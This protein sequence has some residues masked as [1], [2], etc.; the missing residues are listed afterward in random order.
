M[1]FFPDGTIVVLNGGT[2][3]AGTY[4]FPDESHL[5]I[6]DAKEV[7]IFVV[8]IAD[9]TFSITLLNSSPPKTIVFERIHTR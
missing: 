7:N 1:Q 4:S 3:T 5:K 8:T 6:Q 2:S 9:N